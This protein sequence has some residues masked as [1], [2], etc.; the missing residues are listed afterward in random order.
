MKIYQ[1]KLSPKS[2]FQGFPSSDTLFGA[3]CWGIRWIYSSKTLVDILNDFEKH[4]KFIISS[5]FPYFENGT[6][7]LPFYPKPIN[8]GLSADEINEMA[9]TKKEKVNIITKYKRF[10]KSEFVS[11]SL[12]E[13]TINGTSEKNLFQEYLNG[14]I[15]L[16][17]KL[18]LGKDEHSVFFSNKKPTIKT[19]L[20][21]KN[22]IDRLTMSTGEEGQTFYQQ[23]YFSSPEFKL[24]FLIKT[25]DID[26]FKPV[27]RYLED[28]GIGGNRTTGKGMFRIE[29][30]GEKN[31]GDKDSPTFITL[32]KY[33]PDVSEIDTASESMLYEL[34]PFRS[35]V[36][37]DLEFKGSDIWK[38]KVMYCKEGSIFKA[39]ERKE[40]YGQCPVVKEISRQ[41]IRQNAIAFPVFGNFGGSK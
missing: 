12:F 1:I 41:K 11:A 14:K 23:E 25:D 13:K 5:A 37:S 33:I 10:K 4:P 36:E 34:L 27:F 16:E 30:I 2:P 17:N 6:N 20:I 35:K 18:L 40:F 32:S 9:E 21:Q 29:I 22:S 28:R 24:H 3:I 7:N 31:I 8:S 15:Q 19:E 39:K 26:F 38:A